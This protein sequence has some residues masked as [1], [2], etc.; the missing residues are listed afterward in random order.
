MVFCSI[1]VEYLARW[2]GDT[3]IVIPFI[4]TGRL[5][6]EV[7]CTVG[8]FG[9]TLYL[10]I[11]VSPDN[12]FLD[13]LKGVTAEYGAASKHDDCGRVDALIPRPAYA[14]NPSLNW[15]PKQFELHPTAWTAFVRVQ[16]VEWLRACGID[17]EPF[18]AEVSS[19]HEFAAGAVSAED[20]DNEPTLLVSDN[21]RVIA[22]HFIYR[23]D[24]ADAATMKEF[25]T[26]FLDA[27]QCTA[28]QSGLASAQ[29]TRG[30]ICGSA[31]NWVE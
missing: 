15:F 21:G 17:I 13:L 30:I 27:V 24:R 3:D 7:D 19:S 5:C 31:R 12:T 6:P 18:T 16:E 25:A 28:A 26:G 8:C 10:R 1:Y 23:A 2:S 20:W 4:T 11:S 22:G 9:S 14:K 29:P